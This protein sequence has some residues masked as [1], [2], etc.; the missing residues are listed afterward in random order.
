MKKIL[1]TPIGGT[2]PIANYKD[3]PVLHICRVYKPDKIVLFMSKEICEFHEKDNRYQYCLDQLGR[4]LNH[5]FEIELIMDKDLSEVQ[6]FDYFI[7]DFRQ[8]LKGIRESEKGAEILLNI[9]SGTPAM[10]CALQTIAALAEH[11]MRAI[12][13]GTPMKKINPHEED[14]Q[15]YDV[16]SYW[17]LNEDNQTSYENRCFEEESLNLLAEIKKEIIVGQ[18]RSYDYVAA[19]DLANTMGDGLSD[20]VLSLLRVAAAR[21]KL[22]K[23][24]IDKERNPLVKEIFPRTGGDVFNIFEY[25]LALD[26]KLKKEEYADFIRAI[27]P[28]IV[29]LFEITVR[30]KCDFNIDEYCTR[31]K[32][33]GLR[34]NRSKL[35][36]RKEILEA[37]DEKY[38]EFKE[39]EVSSDNLMVIIEVLCKDFKIRKLAKELRNIESKIRNIAAHEIVSVTESVIIKSNESKTTPREIYK[40]IKALINSIGFNISEKEWGS[41]DSMN[42]LIIEHI[43]A[44]SH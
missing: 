6:R 38:K 39:S 18:V 43:K 40:M 28:L 41:Y 17:T 21:L 13:V 10:K 5:K 37:F 22:D 36:N 33:K 12:Q 3:G 8:R 35:A 25:T 7:K 26:I 20:N 4:Q 27:T 34:W 24:S 11:K 32:D 23:S 2:D 29:D 19:L 31:T 16:E 14:K 44:G 30:K 9:S 42:E 15:D 1:F